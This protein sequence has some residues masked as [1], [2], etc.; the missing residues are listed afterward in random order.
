MNGQFPTHSG[1]F[2]GYGMG[3]EFDK[4]HPSIPSD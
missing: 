1:N 4:G 2:I 3:N